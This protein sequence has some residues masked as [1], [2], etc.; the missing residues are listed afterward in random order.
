VL[1][2]FFFFFFFLSP[3]SKVSPWSSFLS[4]E[5][6]AS[7][8]SDS[9]RRGVNCSFPLAGERLEFSSAHWILQE[10]PPPLPRRDGEIPSL[11]VISPVFLFFSSAGPEGHE[12]GAAFSAPIRK[13]PFPPYAQ[14]TN[15]ASCNRATVFFLE[16]PARFKTAFFRVFQRRYSISTE[17][18]RSSPLCHT[19]SQHQLFFFPLR[20]PGLFSPFFFPMPLALSS[21][22]DVQ[23]SDLFSRIP[24]SGA[25]I[26]L[27]PFRRRPEQR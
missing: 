4:F 20:A 8:Y 6:E 1:E 14:D 23:R 3:P 11:F 25:R 2:H 9:R 26:H 17:G 19:P 18:G 7:C 12:W 10:Q 5:K 27:P 13:S 21:F 22:V 24:G 16:T 15:A